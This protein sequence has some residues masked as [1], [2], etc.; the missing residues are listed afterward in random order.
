LTVA[1]R[2]QDEPIGGGRSGPPALDPFWL[3]L[4]LMFGGAGI[5]ATAFAVNAWLLRGPTWGR[6][7][8]VAIAILIGAPVILFGLAMLRGGGM[9]PGS[10]LQYAM[11]LFIAWKLGLAYWIFFLQ[12]TSHALYQYFGGAGNRGQVASMGAVLVMAGGYFKPAI[13]NAFDSPFW[14][15]MVN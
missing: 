13:V 8:G 6:E 11:L 5:G 15:I 7:V 4:A 14:Q 2:I 3:L 12:Q 9:L 10:S 1:Y